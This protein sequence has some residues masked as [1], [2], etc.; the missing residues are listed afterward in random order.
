MKSANNELMK[1]K[2]QYEL[3]CDEVSMLEASKMQLQSDIERSEAEINMCQHELQC[4]KDEVTSLKN[5]C[6]KMHNEN[7]V[8]CL[9]SLF[10]NND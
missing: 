6:D 8:S 10:F 7:E 5:K 2:P 3:K 9:L 1:L 4:S